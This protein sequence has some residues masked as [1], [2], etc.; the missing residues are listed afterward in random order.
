MIFWAVLGLVVIGVLFSWLQFRRV[1]GTKK[2]ESTGI[3][4]EIEVAMTGFRIAS[5]VLGVLILG[6]SLGFFYLYL[7]FVYPIIEIK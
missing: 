6:L 1:I 5:P 7:Q 4:G 2:G 3:G